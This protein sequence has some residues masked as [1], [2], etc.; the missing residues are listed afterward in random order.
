M[1]SKF[2]EIKSWLKNICGDSGQNGGSHYGHKALK[3]GYISR[4]N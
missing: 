4:S 1:L 3:F 2:V